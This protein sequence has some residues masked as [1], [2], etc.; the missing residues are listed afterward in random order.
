MV[1]Y[2]LLIPGHELKTE[3]NTIDII[4]HESDFFVGHSLIPVLE[5]ILQTEVILPFW[6]EYLL[7][8][9]L[10]QLIQPQQN[11]QFCIDHWQIIMIFLHL[12]PTNTGLDGQ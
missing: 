9:P 2:N 8:T 6:F 10:S 4:Q 7:K 3:I 1:L 11:R 12:Q 5:F